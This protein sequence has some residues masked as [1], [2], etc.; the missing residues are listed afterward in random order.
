M[1]K[2]IFLFI[3][4]FST[5]NSFSQLDSSF[6][7]TPS[8][9]SATFYGQVQIDGLPADTNDFIGAFD[10]LGSCVGS[11]QLIVNNSIAYINLVIYGDDPSTPNID[12]GM[13]ASENFYLK[14]F[15]YS[16][17]QI[18]DYP[19]YDSIYSFSGWQN[20]NGAPL[21]NYNSPDTIYNFI[22]CQSFSQTNISSCDSVVWNNFT[23]FISGIYTFT[24]SNSNGCDSIATLN[25]TIDSITSSFN[26]ITACDSYTWNGNNYNSSVNYKFTTSNS[27]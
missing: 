2:I 24:T 13:D 10:S 16:E 20:N 21:I 19:S 26:S 9:Y 5:F 25:L 1:K 11:V 7:F 17:S 15:D 22:T 3:F 6:F 23:Y 12:E 27:N 8:P 18:F 4:L 14:L